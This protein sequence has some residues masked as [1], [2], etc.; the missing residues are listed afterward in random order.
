MLQFL[1]EGVSE[2]PVKEVHRSEKVEA[3]SD[4]EDKAVRLGEVKSIID[5]CSLKKEDYGIS[6]STSRKVGGA[7]MNLKSN[8]E[9]GMTKASMVSSNSAM[10]EDTRD[11]MGFRNKANKSRAHVN[12]LGLKELRGAVFSKWPKPNEIYKCMSDCALEMLVGAPNANHF[13]SVSTKS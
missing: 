5:N 7:F 3:A 12:L 6:N 4:R 11:A 1:D 9:R 8:E 13:C 10:G 2:K